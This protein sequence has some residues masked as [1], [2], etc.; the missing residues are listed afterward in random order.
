MHRAEVLGQVDDGEMV[1]SSLG[2]EV[3]DLITSS[4]PHKPHLTVEQFVIM[5]NHVHLLTYIS[6]ENQN[7]TPS[8]YVKWL[9]GASTVAYRAAVRAGS[10][11]DLG[12]KLWQAGF[13]DDIVRN[14]AH[15]ENAR[16]YIAEN[17]A[18]WS[19][20]EMY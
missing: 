8:H 9:K 2:S 7:T 19:E 18:R 14:D 3:H 15:L 13:N 6:I 4:S 16:R 10:C 20:D 12:S 11:A 1:L 17:V 5:P